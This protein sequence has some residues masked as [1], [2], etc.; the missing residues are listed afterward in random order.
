MPQTVSLWRDPEPLLL[1]STSPTRRALLACAG[2]TVE[3]RAPGVDE[4]AVEAQAAGLSPEGLAERLAAAKANAVAAQMPD[5]VVIGA[6]QVLDL[7]GTVF[8]KPA[9]RAGAAAHL[10][11]LQGRTHALHSAVA[12][13]IDGAV[14]DGFVATA[15]LTMRPLDEAG[16]AAYLDAAGPAV[17]GSVGAYQLEGVGIHLFD[18]IEGDHSTILGLPLLPLLARLRARGLLA[19]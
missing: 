12:L 3:T 11:R 6:D 19:F 9:D 8:H 14:V 13:A 5:R 16:I 4:R 2:L 10:A 18:R 1:A 17:I 7:D 15:R